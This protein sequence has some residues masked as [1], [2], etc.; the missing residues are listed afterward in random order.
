MAHASD[1]FWTVGMK[2]E[3]KFGDKPFKTST[4]HMILDSGVSY[5]L[6]PS[7][8]FAKLSS[9]LD[10]EYGVSCKKGDQKD[11]FSA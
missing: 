7:E 2:E 3:V 10:T 9:F 11:N 1:F 6:V 8:D 4:N 5:A